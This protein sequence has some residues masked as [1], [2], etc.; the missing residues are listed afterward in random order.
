MYLVDTV[1]VEPENV[2]PYLALVESRVKP[3]MTGA[4]A[5]FE[6]CRIT[7][8]DLGRPVDVEVAWSFTDNTAWNEIRRD[9]VL[10]PIYYEC[11]E[12]LRALRMGGTRRF[13]RAAP[14][15]AGPGR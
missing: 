14:D 7:A 3:L 10:D 12:A 2:S 9:L 4:G 6:F 11:A 15:G 5:T 8:A 1:A 13:Y